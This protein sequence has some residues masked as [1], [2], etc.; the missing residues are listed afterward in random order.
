MHRRHADA[1]PND[2]GD[3]AK[4]G[5]LRVGGIAVSFVRAPIVRRAAIPAG[6]PRLDA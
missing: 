4:S 1:L 6:D 3:Q 5:D 2:G